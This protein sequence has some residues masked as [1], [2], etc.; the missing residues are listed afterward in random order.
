MHC[1]NASLLSNRKE[2]SPFIS[3]RLKISRNRHWPKRIDTHL[4]LHFHLLLIPTCKN[5]YFEGIRSNFA[6]IF[7]TLFTHSF[8]ISL[9][10]CLHYVAYKHSIYKSICFTKV[11]ETD[12]IC[13]LCSHAS[14]SFLAFM[15]S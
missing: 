13:G 11:C 4:F 2:C 14:S 7:H 1:K 10:H 3:V 5:L 6:G 8:G 15:C 12:S 9:S